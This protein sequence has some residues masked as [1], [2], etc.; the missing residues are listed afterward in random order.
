MIISGD[1]GFTPI[2]VDP[3]PPGDKLVDCSTAV[4]R[5]SNDGTTLKN[6][7]PLDIRTGDPGVTVKG[8]EVAGEYSQTATWAD[9]YDEGNAAAVRV[10]GNA[11][12]DPGMSSVIIR[13]WRIDSAW[14]GIRVSWNCPNFLIVR[15]YLSKL[16]DDAFENDRLNSGTIRNVLVDGA[17]AGLSV[18][19]SSS[20]PVDGS[21]NTVT[22]ENVLMRMM[23]TS[24]S[25]ETTHGSFFKTDSA[26]PNTMTPNIR[27]KNVVL[28]METPNHR[29]YRSTREAWEKMGNTSVDCFLLNLSDEPLPD[30]YPMPPTGW[31]IVQGASA[32]TMWADKKAA[33][34]AAWNGE[35]SEPPSEPPVEPPPP[36]PEPTPEF[37]VTAEFAALESAVGNMQIALEDTIAAKDDINVAMAALKAKLEGN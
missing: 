6:P 17:F 24:Y 10:G 31:T 30:D 21:M 11:K 22:L 2:K 28:A 13:D 36:E 33:W 27:C 35:V 12:T 26:T 16:R 19:P 15:C 32:R 14:D 23:L 7:Y 18:D 34:I 20:S 37:D 3:V 25:G 1:Q 9:L 5:T 4:F 8:G 29:S